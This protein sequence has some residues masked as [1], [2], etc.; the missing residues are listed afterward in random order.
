MSYIELSQFLRSKDASIRLTKQDFLELEKN[1]S[2][3]YTCQKKVFSVY[4]VKSRFYPDNYVNM[5]CIFNYF[6]TK[7]SSEWFLVDGTDK[8]NVCFETQSKFFGITPI[9]TENHCFKCHRLAMD[10][11]LKGELTLYNDE[12]Y[13]F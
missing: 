6:A 5:R 1:I 11:Y 12:L 3:K 2:E 10:K 13:K 4:C 7:K 8:F 9:F